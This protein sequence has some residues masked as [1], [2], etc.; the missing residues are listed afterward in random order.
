M[1]EST[2][3]HIPPKSANLFELIKDIIRVNLSAPRPERRDLLK[4]HPE[5][6]LLTPPLKAG[7]LD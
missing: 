5:A 1:G 6:R 3:P 4:V 2:L 7:R